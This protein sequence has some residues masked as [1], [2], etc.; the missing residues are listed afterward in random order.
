MLTNYEKV[1]EFH[2]IFDLE[3]HNKPQWPSPETFRLRMDLIREEFNEVVEALTEQDLPHIAK[4]LCDLL[5]VVYGTG[6]SFG[7]DL[8]TAFE[9]VH[10]SN[11]SK[12]DKDGKVLRREDGKVL[13]SDQYSP[14]SMEAV[15]SFD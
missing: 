9:E 3:R 10:R 14:A 7:I 15:L 8:D 5:Y 1:L 6:V 2:Q 4:E 12:L 13:K 11:M